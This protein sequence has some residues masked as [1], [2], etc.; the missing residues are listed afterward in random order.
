MKRIESIDLRVIKMAKKKIKI[1]NVSVEFFIN[2]ELG[3]PALGPSDL[4]LY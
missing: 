3:L 1:L 4:T 2:I